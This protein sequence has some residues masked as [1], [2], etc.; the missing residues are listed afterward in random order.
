MS[1]VP[2]IEEYVADFRAARGALRRD[3]IMAD[4]M[5][6]YRMLTKADLQAA[7]FTDAEIAEHAEAAWVLARREDEAFAAFLATAR[8]KAGAGGESAEAAGQLQALEERSKARGEVINDLL[9]LITE[10]EQHLALF[11]VP[12][13]ERA[14]KV[15]A[16]LL[17]RLKGA[18][19][20][21]F[22]NLAVSD[23][24]RSLAQARAACGI[25]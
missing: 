25:S 22:H 10:A 1:E 2:T 14:E 3:V 15:R 20:N 5:V 19:E 16:D 8:A 6:V 12:A 23:H 24:S 4:A 13:T 17:K 18:A 21:T 9:G 11:W 7:G